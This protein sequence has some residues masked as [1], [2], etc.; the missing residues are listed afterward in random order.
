MVE[1]IFVP[2]AIKCQ[3]PVKFYFIVH[4]GLTLASRDTVKYA[5]DKLNWQ[6]GIKLPHR[7]IN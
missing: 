1:F 6:S 4:L 2:Y 7:L 5:N 3:L